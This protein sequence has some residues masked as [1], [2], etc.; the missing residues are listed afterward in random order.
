MFLAHSGFIQNTC[1]VVDDLVHDLAHVVRAPRRGRHDVVE[2]LDAA[3]E[4]DR[5]SPSPAA[6]RRCAAGRTTGS[7]ARSRR[8]SASSATSRS[9]TPRDLRVHA[10][11]RPSPPRSRPPRPP[12]SPGG[13]RRAPSTT[14]PSPSARSRRARGCT[15]C[16]PR[17]GRASPRPSARRRSSRPAR[18]TAR[19]RPR[20]SD[21][22]VDW[23][24]APAESSSHTIGMRCRSACARIREILFSPTAPIDP[25]ITVKSYAATATWRPSIS[26]MPVTAPSAAR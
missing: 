9:A 7:R 5:S 1:A 20:T 3:V 25:A 17:S 22:L 15:R 4:R 8:H 2:L 23:M 14:C 24:R 13:G 10:P 21:P 12:P 11:S 18:G 26:P 6:A 19:P 16:R